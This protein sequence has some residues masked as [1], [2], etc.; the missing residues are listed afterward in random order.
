[1]Y[2]NCATFLWKQKKTKLEIGGTAQREFTRRQKSDKRENLRGW[3]SPRSKVTWPKFQCM[4]IRRMRIVDLGLVNIRACNFF[5]DGP[6][7]T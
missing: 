6:K 7:F 5:S 3:N 2:A 4:S 1:M